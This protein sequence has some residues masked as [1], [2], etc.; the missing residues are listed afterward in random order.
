[1]GAFFEKISAFFS[2][3]F[4]GIPHGIFGAA[5]KPANLGKAQIV[6]SVE[7]KPFALCFCAERQR[8]QYFQ[9][10]FLAA[11]YLFRRLIVAVAALGQD[12]VLIKFAVI[13]MPPLLMVKIFAFALGTVEKFIDFYPYFNGHS[14][15]V[16][17]DMYLH[18]FSSFLNDLKFQKGQ[19]GER[20]PGQPIIGLS[21]QY[22]TEKGNKK[23]PFWEN[24]QKVSN[25]K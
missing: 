21:G 1:V 15:P 24:P 25:E 11:I 6:Q 22:S 23:T 19:G 12:D 13:P 18:D 20:Q 3:R 8:S 17:F 9:H 4:N 5:L 2:Y 10:G 16:D 7:K 14:L